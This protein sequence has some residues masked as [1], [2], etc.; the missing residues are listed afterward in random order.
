[1][2]ADW[3]S[4]AESFRALGDRTR[5]RILAMLKVDE[6]CVCELVEALGISQPAVSQH[7]RRLKQAGWVKENRRGQWV[8][9]SLDGSAYPFRN[10]VIEALPD[11]S[12]AVEELRR[13]GRRAVCE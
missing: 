8:F 9:Y 13:S 6:L 3:D 10:R 12:A 4:L 7:M 2:Q 5:L 11:M 1:M